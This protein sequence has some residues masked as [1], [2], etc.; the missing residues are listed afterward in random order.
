MPNATT[1]SEER[2]ESPALHTTLR[3]TNWSTYSRRSQRSEN[4]FT[5]GVYGPV[6]PLTAGSPSAAGFYRI[7][8]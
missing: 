5:P 2:T 3:Q 1:P 4:Q 6:P 7:V 8:A